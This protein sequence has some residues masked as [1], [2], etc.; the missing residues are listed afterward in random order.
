[1][2]FTSILRAQHSSPQHWPNTFPRP[3]SA[4]RWPRRTSDSEITRTRTVPRHDRYGRFPSQ[5]IWSASSELLRRKFFSHS[6]Q[7][8]QIFYIL[9]TD[10]LWKI[11][12]AGR[13]LENQT[14][15]HFKRTPCESKL[16]Q[17]VR[18]QD[19]KDLQNLIRV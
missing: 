7:I 13:A 16:P 1:M 5:A 19:I 17:T 2:N 11:R 8:L 12:L 3:L 6:D 14:T 9:R 10:C 4:N 18:S 15:R